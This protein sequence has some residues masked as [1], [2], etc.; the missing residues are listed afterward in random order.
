VGAWPRM[1]LGTGI[2]AAAAPY[3]LNHTTI[4]VPVI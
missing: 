4:I 3:I 1:S 2:M